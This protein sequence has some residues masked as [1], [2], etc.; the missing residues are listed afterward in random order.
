MRNPS[1]S[2]GRT[3]LLLGYFLTLWIGFT[4]SLL[5]G[6]KLAEFDFS[7]SS[8]ASG[9]LVGQDNWGRVGS[10][11]SGPT[12][13]TGGSVI[14]KCGSNYEQTYHPLNAI[15]PATTGLKTY[16]RLEVNVKNAYRSSTGNGD[17]WF[18]LSANADQSGTL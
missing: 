16:V 3:G 10:N 6:T 7:S 17:Y 9:N 1:L 2:L 11:T 15:S 12:Q 4:G 8:Y 18:G 13:I 14:L 5:S